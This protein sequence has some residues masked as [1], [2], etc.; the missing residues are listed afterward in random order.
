MPGPGRQLVAYQADQLQVKLSSMSRIMPPP[1]PEVTLC[2]HKPQTHSP[3][4]DPPLPA[5]V[6]NSYK[7]AFLGSRA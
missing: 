1:L 2:K 4:F 6:A 3:Y 5:P 7:V